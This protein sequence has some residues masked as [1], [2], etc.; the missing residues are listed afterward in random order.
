MRPT[1]LIESGRIAAGGKD[2]VCKA[3]ITMTQLSTLAYS[4]AAPHASGLATCIGVYSK[5]INLLTESGGLLTLHDATHGLSAAGWLLA[6][7]DFHTIGRK[8][9]PQ[10]IVRLSAE[11]LE[12]DGFLLRRAGRRLNLRLNASAR[13]LHAERLRSVLCHLPKETG[14]YGPLHRLAAAPLSAELKRI[15]ALF[16]QSLSGQRVDW[17]SY[18]GMGPGL[19]PSS[20]DVLVGMLAAAY[21]YTPSAHALRRCPLFAHAQPLERLTTHVSCAYLHHAGKGYFST[22][23]R[24]AVFAL[25]QNGR[26]MAAVARLLS[27]GHTSG[28]DTLLGV[29]LGATAI[30]QLP[31]GFS[32]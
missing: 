25:R 15:V 5:A 23:L 29:W 4:H 26:D 2:N 14:L 12:S 32:L 7:A 31:S 8:I 1:P 9:Q 13:P 30:E 11:G 19:T 21:G 28:A 17:S 22:P 18:I 10:S 16:S 6:D 27:H 24:R 20:D 3:I